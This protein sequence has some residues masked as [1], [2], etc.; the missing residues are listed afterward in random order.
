VRRR[1]ILFRCALRIPLVAAVPVRLMTSDFLFIAEQMLPLLDDKRHEMVA[2]NRG[3]KPKE[4][5]SASK[6]LTAFV[7]KSDVA[8][9]ES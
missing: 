7:R 2:W 1:R 9:S 6:L 8:H 5:K 3:I 4:G